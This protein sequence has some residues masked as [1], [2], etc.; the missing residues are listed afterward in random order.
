MG[1]FSQL[2][3]EILELAEQGSSPEDI[4]IKFSKYGITIEDV[5]EV[6][7]EFNV[8]TKE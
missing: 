5:E 8:E 1:F 3:T 4:A 6:L 7:A 2:A